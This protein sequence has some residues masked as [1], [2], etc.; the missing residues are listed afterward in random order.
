MSD[1]IIIIESVPVSHSGICIAS[2][3]VEFLVVSGISSGIAVSY[4]W[5][6]KHSGGTDVLVGIGTGYTLASPL[7]ADEIYVKIIN[8]CGGCSDGAGIIED[9]WFKFNDVSSGIPQVFYI[10]LLASFDYAILSIVL[11]CGSGVSTMSGATVLIDGVVPVEWTAHATTIDIT[12][13]ITETEA[14]DSNV[15]LAGES[16]TLTTSGN[17][18]GTPTFIM[19]KIK[20]RRQ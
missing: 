18:S 15:V 12:S 1:P 20:I 8:C 5:Y 19:G 6:V 10:D 2:G 11:Q 16:L 14:I 4:Q 7:E 3:P 13:V 9:I 17:D